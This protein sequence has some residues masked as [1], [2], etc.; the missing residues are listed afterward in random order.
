VEDGRATEAAAEARTLLESTSDPARIGMVAFVLAG[1]G[2]TV[3]ARELLRRVEALPPD[4]VGRNLGVMVAR[5]GLGDVS[6]ALDAA[7]AAVE[8]DRFEMLVYGL[9]FPAFDPLRASPRF[10]AIVRRLNLDV[11]RLTLPDGGRSR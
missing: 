11:A 6:G 8:K 10:A 1:A 7:E 4:A 2:E 5:T 3:E 9:A